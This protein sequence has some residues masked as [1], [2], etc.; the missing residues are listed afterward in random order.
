[1]KDVPGAQLKSQ[2]TGSTDQQYRED[3]VTSQGKKVVVKADAFELKHL[4]ED[5]AEDL[6]VRCSWSP[7]GIELTLGC[8]KGAAI[9]FAIGGQGQLVEDDESRRH[10]VVGELALK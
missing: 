7:V 6:L 3:A 10:H 5:F 1:M 4:G 9:D 2:P 8:G